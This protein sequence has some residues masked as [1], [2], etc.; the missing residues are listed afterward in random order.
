MDLSTSV[1]LRPSPQKTKA[2][3]DLDSVSIH[4]RI[5]DV[6]RKASTKATRT[7]SSPYSAKPISTKSS[8]PSSAA[9]TGSPVADI[10]SKPTR[11]RRTAGRVVTINGPVK[12]SKEEAD[13][14]KPESLVGRLGK[15]NPSSVKHQKQGRTSES[16]EA[17]GGDESEVH[18]K[19]V[20]PRTP[21]LR[22]S[23]F[24]M[25]SAFLLAQ[26]VKIKPAQDVAS[27]KT[28]TRK[29]SK[30]KGLQATTP[31][32]PSTPK[33]LSKSVKKTSIKVPTPVMKTVIPAVILQDQEMS[34]VNLESTVGTPSLSNPVPFQPLSQQ[35]VAFPALGHRR[36]TQ[37]LGPRRPPPLTLGLAQR[38]PS[39]T[40]DPSY[41]AGF[42]A[43]TIYPARPRP[44]PV[45]GFSDD[46]IDQY[47]SLRRPSLP[48]LIALGLG[49]GRGASSGQ[50]T[51]RLRSQSLV[52]NPS[53]RSSTPGP[54]VSPLAPSQVFYPAEPLD[55]YQSLP[56]GALLHPSAPPPTY[57]RTVYTQ[58]SQFQ[59]WNQIHQPPPSPFSSAASESSLRTPIGEPEVPLPMIS[60][61]PPRHVSF[62][63]PE[64]YK[65]DGLGLTGLES[66][67]LGISLGG[68]SAFL[69]SC[70][71]CEPADLPSL[72]DNQVLLPS[73]PLSPTS[74]S[75][76]PAALAPIL[77]TTRGPSLI[78]L[79][80]V[81]TPS[82]P[83][84]QPHTQP[85]TTHL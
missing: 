32:S 74:I 33:A 67:L 24:L 45:R 23:F 28:P 69:W 66:N 56:V 9:L 39:A 76:L 83:Y 2:V 47:K 53:S 38:L 71:L 6:K 46:K 75:L 41:P 78:C 15:C 58:A 21:P 30:T 50:R 77:P 20:S 34:D 35:T 13:E 85:L 62:S 79:L 81:N 73:D 68:A 36:Q 16:S 48:S 5:L 10:K 4:F 37:P 70:L 51:T 54:A 29:M 25:T 31:P 52:F 22:T 1:R 27:D 26:S 84:T 63:A 14:P 82:S 42:P 64:G 19:P 3:A 40:F 49:G 43:S 12:S 59:T 57:G 17:D 18:H 44:A 80:P 7:V 8:R 55:S 65:G 60:E 72:S 11:R 61:S